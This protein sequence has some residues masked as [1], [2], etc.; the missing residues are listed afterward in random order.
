[1]REFLADYVGQYEVRSGFVLNITLE[2]D[3]LWVQPTGQRKAELFPE[4]ETKFFFKVVDAQVTFV[5]DAA[6]KVTRLVL[7]QGGDHDAKRI[8]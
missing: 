5:K 2:A 7:H 1:M 4:S 3:K 6:G 8:N